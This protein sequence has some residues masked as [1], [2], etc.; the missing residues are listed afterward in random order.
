MRHGS[1]TL[2]FRDDSDG[3]GELVATVEVHG[4]AGR[5][6]AWFGITQ[7]DEFA[8]A[9]GQF[10]LPVD[11]RYELAGGFWKEHRLVQ[12]HLGIEVYPIGPRGRI[13]IQVRVATEY[14]ELW[15][16]F[17]PEAQMMARMEIIT[18]YQ[19]LLY[20]SKGLKD[21][22]RGSSKQVRLEGEPLD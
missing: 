14:S 12:E 3:T 7:I 6:S 10:P 9:L 8:D 4:F 16:G 15:P 21:L 20:F 19:P 2:E 11:S 22:V 1:L 13:G 5:G 17:R 18:S